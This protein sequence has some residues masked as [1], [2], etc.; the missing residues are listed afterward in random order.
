MVDEANNAA[1]LGNFLS[2]IP[3]PRT[4]PAPQKH[5]GNEQNSPFGKGKDVTFCDD[6]GEEGLLVPLQKGLP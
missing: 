5:G 6:E 2:A 3:H 4:R 1:R